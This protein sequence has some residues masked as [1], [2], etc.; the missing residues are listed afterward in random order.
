MFPRSRLPRVSPA[1][2]EQSVAPPSEKYWPWHL[3]ALRGFPRRN[4]D[5]EGTWTQ[6]VE[7]DVE[8]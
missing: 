6:C 5:P 1:Q 7:W 4:A 3:M 8:L 2:S